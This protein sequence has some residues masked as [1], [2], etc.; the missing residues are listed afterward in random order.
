MWEHSESMLFWKKLNKIYI[1]KFR[2]LKLT[3]LM[4]RFNK[5]YWKSAYTSMCQE[6]LNLKV[7]YSQPWNNLLNWTKQQNRPCLNKKDKEYL[8]K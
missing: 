4:Y 6:R 5:N 7:N 3:N 1:F 2:S 8:N